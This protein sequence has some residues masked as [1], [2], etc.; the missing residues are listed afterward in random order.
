MFSSLIHHWPD[1]V[2]PCSQELWAPVSKCL[3]KGPWQDTKYH[4]ANLK[5]IVYIQYCSSVSINL[6]W[7]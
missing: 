4:G 7:V 5:V 6:E 3:A 2:V 1:A